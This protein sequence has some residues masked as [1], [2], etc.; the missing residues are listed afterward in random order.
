M[1]ACTRNASFWTIRQ[2]MVAL[3]NGTIASGNMHRVRVVTASL[4]PTLSSGET[5]HPHCESFPRAGAKAIRYNKGGNLKP[6]LCDEGRSPVRFHGSRW[7]C[8][9]RA[10]LE[11]S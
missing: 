1:M 5:P 6:L 8:L 2:G 3:T 7:K 11:L 10:P 4:T 9:L